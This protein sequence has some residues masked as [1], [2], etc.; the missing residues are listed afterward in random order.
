MTVQFMIGTGLLRHQLWVASFQSCHACIASL[1][2]PLCKDW[3]LWSFWECL[4]RTLR[5]RKS[6]VR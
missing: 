5:G 4:W 1:S 2:A 3:P 6:G